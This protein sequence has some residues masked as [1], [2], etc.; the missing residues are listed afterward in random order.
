MCLISFTIPS[1]C[2]PAKQNDQTV[3]SREDDCTTD[4]NTQLG[5]GLIWTYLIF[6]LN[7]FPLTNISFMLCDS[8]G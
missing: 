2:F 3:S 1:H 8:N 5:K 6:M 7:M 4:V